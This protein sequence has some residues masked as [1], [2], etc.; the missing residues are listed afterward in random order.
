MCHGDALRETKGRSATSQANGL[1]QSGYGATKTN[2]NSGTL[3]RPEGNLYQSPYRM[4]DCLG[5]GHTREPLYPRPGYSVTPATRA[6][7]GPAHTKDPGIESTLCYA[8][9]LPGR[10]SDFWPGCRPDSNRESLKIGPSTGRRP[11]FAAFPTR[12]RPKSGPAARFSGREHYCIHRHGNETYKDEQ[13]RKSS[14]DP[15][16]VDAKARRGR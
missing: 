4:P 15:K 13:R 7:P 1:S 9:V 2:R 16:R 5:T 6:H 14:C 3:P 12:I 8:I 11:D 10:I